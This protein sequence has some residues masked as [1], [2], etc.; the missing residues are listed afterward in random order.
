MKGDKNKD[1]AIKLNLSPRT[2]E[3]HIDYI[4]AKLHCRSK[5]DLVIQLNKIIKS[6]E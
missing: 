2:I 6:H 3:T 4:K 1:I 5:L